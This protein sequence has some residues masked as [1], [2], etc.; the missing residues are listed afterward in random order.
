VAATEGECEDVVAGLRISFKGSLVGFDI[1][2]DDIEGH[3][4]YVVSQSGPVD[5]QGALPPGWKCKGWVD[6]EGARGHFSI[7]L[8]A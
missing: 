4:I 6:S 3:L 7:V 5:L 8:K 2:P 1:L